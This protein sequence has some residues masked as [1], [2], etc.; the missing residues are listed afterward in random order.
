MPL[1]LR[2]DCDPRNRWLVENQ[3]DAM[4]RLPVA[5]A[6]VDALALVPPIVARVFEHP[7]GV[8][9]LEGFVVARRPKRE[10]VALGHDLAS[11]DAFLPIATH[12]LS[13]CDH[14]RVVI[15]EAS[16]VFRSMPWLEADW[17]MR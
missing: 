12:G 1:S 4:L 7:S 2:L 17:S 13:P 11:V 3:L 5:L 16:E 10:V 14:A 9:L 15:A 6:A 8:R